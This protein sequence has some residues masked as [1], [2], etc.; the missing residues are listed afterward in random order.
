VSLFS[1]FPKSSPKS[2]RLGFLRF[3]FF[4]YVMSPKLLADMR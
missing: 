2:K 1:K 4:S 3:F